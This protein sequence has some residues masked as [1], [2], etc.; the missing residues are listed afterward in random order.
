MVS[1]KTVVVAEVLPLFSVYTHWGFELEQLI[2]SLVLHVGN[3]EHY[4]FVLICFSIL[5]FVQPSSN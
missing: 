2:K 4:V 1:A 5:D 3:M